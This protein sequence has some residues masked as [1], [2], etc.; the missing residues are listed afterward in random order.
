MPLFDTLLIQFPP[1]LITKLAKIFC[2]DAEIKPF[3]CSGENDVIVVIVK[4]LI[5]HSSVEIG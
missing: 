2:S 3:R 1:Q 4:S 5:F